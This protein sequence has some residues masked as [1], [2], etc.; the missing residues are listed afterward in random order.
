MAKTTSTTSANKKAFKDNFF[1]AKTTPNE[2]QAAVEK[3]IQARVGMLF[4]APFFGQLAVRLQL[5][6]S[7]EWLSTAA[8]DG[9]CFYYNTKFINALKPRECEFLF[10]HEI[11]HV[12]YDH[13][14][15]CDNRNHMLFNIACDYVVNADVI[16][17][18]IGEQIT[19]VP[20]LYDKKYAGMTAEEVYDQ[21]YDEADKIDISD[22][23]GQTLDDHMDSDG[24][25]EGDSEGGSKG[26]SEGKDNKDS[27]GKRPRKPTKEEADA[28]R[29]E[30]REAMLNA[31]NSTNPGNLPGNLK[32]LINEL[33]HP[34]M[35][36]RD[37]LQQQVESTVRSDFS[38]MKPSKRSWHIDVVLPGLKPQERIDIAVAIDT[39]GSIS[40]QDLTDFLSEIHGIM[41]SYDDYSIYTYCF[42]TETYNPQTFTPDNSH[43]LL[44]Y[45]P[46]GFGGTDFS[47]IWQHL[48]KEDIQPKKLIIFT[49]MCAHFPD[50]YADY[51]DT[52]WIAHNSDSVAPFGITAKF[53]SAHKNR[54]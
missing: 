27:N 39:S 5:V 30:F 42:D 46:Q 13:M 40:Q 4:K 48:Q 26:N 2:D 41:S 54:K 36:W 18:Q 22:L 35:N 12:C 9:R 19:T 6:K 43:D 16:D 50:E 37:L 45:E 44:T 3:I 7:N 11:L 32:R 8:T 1:G 29:D 25:G 24:D 52:V 23:F 20:L 28:L 33:T 10:A 38:W 34:V 15:R 51:C 17:Q 21:L 47:A 14:D 49:D 53:E 31:A